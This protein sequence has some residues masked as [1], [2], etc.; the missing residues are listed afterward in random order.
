M[1]GKG[2]RRAANSCIEQTH[3]I[4][5]WG[6]DRIRDMVT[7]RPDWC[8]SR[9][10]YW[11]VP[12]ALFTSKADDS[13]HPDTAMLLER[14]ADRVE[15]EGL[16]AWFGS[17]VSDWGVD[18]SYEKCT[19]ILDVWF[20]S[21]AVHQCAFKCTHE[22]LVKDEQQPRADLYLEGSDQHRGWFQSS[23]LLSAAGADRPPFK[24]VLTHG[25]TVDE[26]GRKMSKSI[27]NVVSPKTIADTLGADVLR[28]WVSSVDYESD[29]SVSPKLI[30]HAVDAYRRIRNTSRFL[31][32]NLGDFDPAK[33]QVPVRAMLAIDRWALATASSM[34]K[35]VQEAYRRYEL[36]QV[37]QKVLNYCV[38]DLSAV[39][40]DVI[41]DRLY[42]LSSKSHGRRSAQ[43][44]LFHIAHA[45]VRWI[46]PILSF[47]ADE[48]WRAMPGHKNDSVFAQQ[49]HELPDVRIDDVNWPLL[50]R[51]RQIAQKAL[52]NLRSTGE[53][54]GSLDAE[55]VITIRSDAEADLRMV[56]D[57]LRFWLLTSEAS[58]TTTGK[59]TTGNE[60][61]QVVARRSAAIKCARCRHRRTDVEDRPEFPELCARC[62]TNVVGV[63][64]Q[65]RYF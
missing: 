22:D 61:I 33:D 28:L 20:D 18:A 11:G 29:I 26:Q 27:G 9:Q 42:T 54:G 4:P 24:A 37:Y 32:G 55:V 16:E 40:L 36:K 25:F 39:Y 46:T 58:L 15:S 17:T 5:A 31:L 14:I 57:E 6:E 41:K 43:T 47:A 38:V 56:A 35:Q 60:E 23:L 2:L 52:E 51:T 19:D 53:I 49:W 34:Q 3:W 48:I 30:A 8:I 12:L 50:L 7:G 13:L 45:L 1:D 44:T 59:T 64:E 21:G 63:G 65:R 62:I 10:R